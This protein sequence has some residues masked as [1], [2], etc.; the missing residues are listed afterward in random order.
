MLH[1]NELNDDDEAW[2]GIMLETEVAEFVI[3]RQM[4]GSSRAAP[5]AALCAELSAALLVLSSLVRNLRP[6][7]RRKRP[8]LFPGVVGRG[9]GPKRGT[10][11]AETLSEH[12]QNQPATKS[13]F[14]VLRQRTQKKYH[15]T[16][17]RSTTRKQE[18]CIPLLCQTSL[19]P[20]KPI[21][22]YQF[23]LGS[24][25]EDIATSPIAWRRQSCGVLRH[26]PDPPQFHV[27]SQVW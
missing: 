13:L 11:E 27:P 25:G 5:A 24:R 23:A 14:A 12:R 8:H 16:L 10:N 18:V 1:L 9:P 6:S 26:N 7:S 22:W 19:L 3:C 17:I 4:D 15:L 20:A 2:L 21:L